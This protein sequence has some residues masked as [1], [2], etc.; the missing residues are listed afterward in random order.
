VELSSQ[1]TVTL[2]TSITTCFPAKVTGITNWNILFA[3]AC[4]GYTEYSITACYI[5]YLD[6]NE[7]LS[8]TG[9]SDNCIP[10]CY[11]GDRA[12]YITACFT[13]YK[14]NFLLL[15]HFLQTP[16]N[17]SVILA[18]QTF[19]KLAVKLA[20]QMPLYVTPVQALRLACFTHSICP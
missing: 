1:L 13:G 9:Y 6:T 2:S 15:T 19:L 14:G 16:P 11:I 3:T 8:Y 5:A 12:A 4:I 7:Y 10:P 18:T 17:L 20:I